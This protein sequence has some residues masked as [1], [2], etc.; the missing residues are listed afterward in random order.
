MRQ[1]KSRLSD[2][3]GSKSLDIPPES[4]L[5]IMLKYWDDWEL[6]KGKDKEKM[7]QF[8]MIKW[9]KE[10]LRPHVFWPVFGSFEN[11][12]CQALNLYVNSKEPFNQEET[13]YAALW[14]GASNSFPPTQIFNPLREVPLGGNQGGI[15]FVAV[16]LNTSDVRNFKKEMG[17]LL[18]DPL[19]VAE[20][21]DQFLGPNTYT[22]EEMQS[23]LGILF[24]T[25]ERGMIRQ[26]GMRLWERQNQEGAP[27]DVKWPNTN[28]NWDHQAAQGRQNMRDLRT[29]MTQGIKE[30]VPRGQNINK[31]FNEYQHRDESPTEWLE[32]LR[33]SLQMYSGI[34]PESPVGGA[35]LRTQ[36]VAKSWEDIRKK[37]EKLDDW[38]EKGLEELL[39]EAQKVYVRRDEEKQKAKAKIFV[40]A[41]RESQKPS[42]RESREGSGKKQG[43]REPKDKRKGQDRIPIC[44]YC[45]KKG[46]LQRNC[47]KKKQDEKM[48]KED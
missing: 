44:Y 11:W 19:G 38:Q 30:S 47:R 42:G 24:T 3:R 35:L 13:D 33:R 41:I 23:I 25:E 6:R 26:A 18:D 46:H 8:C 31:A 27:G 9:P 22:W 10:P 1:E 15:G 29:I 4:P 36:F 7:A 16:P 39:R 37:L 21:L 12:V 17:S 32:R 28:P 20:R 34:D 48:F 2:L 5:G 40:A 43:E 45:G 14:I